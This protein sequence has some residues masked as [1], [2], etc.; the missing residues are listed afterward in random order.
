MTKEKDK[1]SANI[2]NLEKMLK[3]KEKELYSIQR[4]S[5]ALSSTL[6]L[7]EL[8]KLIMNSNSARIPRPAAAGLRGQGASLKKDRFS[9]GGIPPW[10]GCSLLQGILQSLCQQA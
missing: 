9:Y 1:N 8:L 10:R 6:K 2:N 4:I 7:D 5:R 3:Q